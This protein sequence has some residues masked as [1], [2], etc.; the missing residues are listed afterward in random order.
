M[1]GTK[2]LK[3]GEPKVPVPTSKT[4]K[5]NYIHILRRTLITY[6]IRG[7]KNV[8]MKILKLERQK[9]KTLP[10][11]LLMRK[12]QLLKIQFKTLVMES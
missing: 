6:G 2:K 5:V 7:P 12:G 1:R 4:F 8:N 11:G 3:K 9:I 10:E